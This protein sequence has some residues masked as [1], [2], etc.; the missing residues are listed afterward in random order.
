LIPISI[1]QLISTINGKYIGK[2]IDY[3]D[4]VGDFSIDTR[5]LKNDDIFIA[6]IGERFDGMTL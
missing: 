4:F 6:I 1:R 3:V 2:K 5:T